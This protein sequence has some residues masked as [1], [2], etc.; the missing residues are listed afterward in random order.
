MLEQNSISD[1][2]HDLLAGGI[3]GA[4]SLVE[5]ALD[6]RWSW[7]HATDDVWE[8]LDRDLWNITHN[9]W[10]VLR[11]VSRDRIKTVLGDSVFRNYIKELVKQ[12]RGAVE[13][14]AWFQQ[15]Y[16]ETALSGVAYFSMEF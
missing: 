11:T 9:P 8:Q 1:P 16:P 15:N 2:I 6:M 13:D 5:L 14:R 12:S 3:D 10:A 7:N 4:D